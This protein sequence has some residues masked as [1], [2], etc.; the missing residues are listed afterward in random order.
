VSSGLSTLSPDVLREGYARAQAV[1]REHAKSFFFSSLAFFGPRRR[2]AFALY[3]F[4]RRLDDMVDAESHAPVAVLRSRLDRARGVVDALFQGRPLP[5]GQADG[6]AGTWHPAELAA[7]LDTVQRYRI[8]RAPFDGL[9]D[10]MEMDLSITR[11]RTWDELRLYCH[12]VAGVVGLMM[13]PVLGYRAPAALPYADE[14]GIAMQLT[15][16]LRD[17]AEDWRRGRLYLPTEELGQFGLGEADLER[18]VDAGTMHGDPRFVAFFRMQVERA[19]ASYALAQHGIPLLEGAGARRLVRLMSEVYG[20]I[21]PAIERQELDVFRG[22][23]HVTLWGKVGLALRVLFTPLRLPALPA[24]AP[25][26]QPQDAPT[27]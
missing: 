4:C 9:L 21:L 27:P 3:A 19:R 24:G 10:G 7:F 16:I 8:P 25:A 13:T 15:N 26:A 1:T 20:G 6:V 12:R 5:Q 22:R 2:A 23:A 14:L 17:V 18:A 11:Y